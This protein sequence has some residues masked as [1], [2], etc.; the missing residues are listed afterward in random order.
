MTQV[1]KRFMS[2][3]PSLSFIGKRASIAIH[4]TR[5]K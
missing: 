2:Q 3:P 1:G 4:I 5:E